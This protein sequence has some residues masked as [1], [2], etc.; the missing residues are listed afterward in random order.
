MPVLAFPGA[1]SG[2]PDDEQP[3]RRVD[4]RS[5][6]AGAVETFLDSLGAATTRTGYARTL[7]RLTATAGPHH[8]VADLEPD[9]YAAVMA[10]WETA[11]AATWNRHLSALISFTTWAQRQYL[12]ATNPAR[13]LSRR[14][15]I[16]RGDRAIPA[17]RLEKLF[18]DDRHPLRERPGCCPA[19]SPVAPPGRCS[20]QT[21]A[22][23]P[24][25]AGRQRPPTSAPSRG[26]A[27]C[28]T[29]AR[30]SCSRLP[31]PGST[32][33]ARGGPCISCATRH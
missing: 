12:L 27:G 29:R 18:T 16:Q 6:V 17:T 15:T 24:P 31:R 32:R 10:A 11:A 5:C 14:E 22:L 3:D 2:H 21:G 1:S 33:T 26:A 25:G 20:W 4:G 13:R 28:P 30:S 9:H 8:P 19:Y 23:L 7:V